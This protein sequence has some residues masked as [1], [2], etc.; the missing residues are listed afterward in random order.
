MP[1]CSFCKTHYEFPRGLTIFLN[2]GRTIFFCSSKCRRN[3]GLG[4]DPRKVN[5]VRKSKKTSRK[6]ARE[7][8]LVQ[9]KEEQK[10]EI[11]A[12]KEEKASKK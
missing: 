7:E 3:Q 6:E 11:P 5:W 8:R 9:I 10:K 12:V 4:R 1:T 2:D